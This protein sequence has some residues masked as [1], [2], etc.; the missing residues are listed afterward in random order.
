MR[1]SLK[2]KLVE[3]AKFLILIVLLTLFG[4]ALLII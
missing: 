3:V 4:I 1:I 2:K